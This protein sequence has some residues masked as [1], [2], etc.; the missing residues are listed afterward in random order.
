MIRTFCLFSTK[1]LKQFGNE[2]KEKF[3]FNFLA[4]HIFFPQKKTAT[5]TR[6]ISQKEKEKKFGFFFSSKQIENEKN[7]FPFGFSLSSEMYVCVLLAHITT[8]T[9]IMTMII[10]LTG[11]CRLYSMMMMMKMME[12]IE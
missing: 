9:I 6:R 3:K 2:K 10:I 4:H 8:T 5:N 1:I 11:E 7:V 12:A